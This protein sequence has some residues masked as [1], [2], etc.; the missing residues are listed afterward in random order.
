MIKM[1]GDAV[2]TQRISVVVMIVERG[3]DGIRRSDG[4]LCKTSPGPAPDLAV[5]GVRYANG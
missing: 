2:A 1:T 5:M 3:P 4:A